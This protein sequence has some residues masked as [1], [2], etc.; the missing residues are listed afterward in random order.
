[1]YYVILN[2]TDLPRPAPGA[3]ILDVGRVWENP[4]VGKKDCG[5]MTGLTIVGHRGW[6]AENI[7]CPGLIPA[8]IPPGAVGLVRGWFC[9][10]YIL[11]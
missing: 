6:G 10:K 11:K 7:R 9:T 2:Y 8:F 3:G 4:G 1:M 5:R